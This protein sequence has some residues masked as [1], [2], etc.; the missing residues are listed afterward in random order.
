RG[1]WE[2]KTTSLPPGWTFLSDKDSHDRTHARWEGKLQLLGRP[3]GRQMWDRIGEGGLKGE[4]K[5]EM[6]T[7]NPGVNPNSGDK[8]LRKQQLSRWKGPKP[9]TKMVPQSALEAA[10]KGIAFYQ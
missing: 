6:P 7:F 2:N 3:E 5:G 8:L 4:G 1:K 10:R 9:D